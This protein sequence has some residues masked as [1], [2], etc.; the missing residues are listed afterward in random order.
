MVKMED[1]TIERLYIASL[2]VILIIFSLYFNNPN[3]Y[4]LI[5]AVIS[6]LA[7]IIT[8]TKFI[9]DKIFNNGD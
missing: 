7:G 1:K 9:K 5:Y 3:T 6:Y 4:T 2:I 8:P